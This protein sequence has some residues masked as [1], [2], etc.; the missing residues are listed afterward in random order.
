MAWI[1][2]IITFIYLVPPD[3]TVTGIPVVGAALAALFVEGIF[4]IFEKGK[5]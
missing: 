4:A 2:F 5:K 1:A 3:K